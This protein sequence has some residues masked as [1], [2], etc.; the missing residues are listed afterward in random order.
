[1]TAYYLV[2]FAHVLGAIGFCIGIA[3]L[4]FVLMGLRRAQRVEQARALKACWGPVTA[5]APGAQ[6]ADESSL[7]R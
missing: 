4:L 1:M 6:S 7:P 3:T 2:L 5:C